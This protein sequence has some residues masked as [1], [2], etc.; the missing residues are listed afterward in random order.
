MSLHDKYPAFG[1]RGPTDMS[2]GVALGLVA[3]IFMLLRIYVRLRINKFGTTALIWALVAWLFTAIDLVFAVLAALYGIG[4]HI[5]IVAATGQLRNFLKFTWITVF[6]FNLA[7]PSGKVAVAAFLLEING[8]SNPKIRKSL[9]AIAVINVVVNIP[10]A[11][12][13]WLQCSPP[14]AILDPERQHL[15]DYRRNAYYTA[16]VGAIAALSDFYYAI[17]PVYIL[18]PLQI[19]V[20]LKWGLGFLMGCGVLAG[21]AAIVRS[22]AAKFIL[23]AD[24]SY[25]I[26]ILFLWGQV[27][28]W[29]VLITMSIPPVWP[30]FR[31]LAQ[32]IISSTT[33]SRRQS[34]GYKKS[35]GSSARACPSDAPQ[36]PLITT[37]ISVSSAKDGGAATIAPSDVSSRG[38]GERRPYNVLSDN[39]KAHG[40]WVELSEV[41]SRRPE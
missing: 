13:V 31:P 33:G 27:E 5:E 4:N 2:V 22:W 28:E 41:D 29:V 8:Q 37:T 12:I 19:D 24:S 16:F 18:I 9:I 36:P 11:A 3:T 30:L 15:C 1:G 21:V 35:Y 14:D 38:S 39:K 6:F 20:K 10:Q 40:P 25:G 26:G 7:I 17:I 34:R 32:N 23:S